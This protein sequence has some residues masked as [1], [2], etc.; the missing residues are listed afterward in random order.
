MWFG[1]LVTMRWWNG[2]W[3]N[4]A[5]ATFMSYLARRRDATGVAGLRLLHAHPCERLRGRRAG[6]DATDRVPGALAGR[7]ERH[8]RHPHV[9]EGRRRT[10][11]ARAV[12]R[13]RAVPRRDPPVP[14]GSTRTATPRRTT[15]GTPS[16]EETGEPVRRVMDAWI[17]QP[18]YPAITVRARRRVA[19]SRPAPLHPIASRRCH[20]VAGAADR[21][22]GGCGRASRST[23]CWSRRD[24]LELPLVVARGCSWSSNAGWR[25]LRS[26]LLRRRPPGAGS[27]ARAFARSHARS[28]GN[29]WSTTPGRPWSPGDAPA[30][31]FV[32][33]VAG[34]A[35]ET[36]LSVWQAIV[37]GLTWCDR[38]VEGA[39]RPVPRLRPRPR[40]SRAR[41]ARLGAIGGETRARPGA[42]RRP[43][44]R[45]R[46]PRATTQRPRRRLAR[47]SRI[48]AGAMSRGRRPRRST[49]WRS[50]VDRTTTSGSARRRGR[51]D[52]AGAGAL[53]VR[54]R[55]VPRPGAVRS[56]VLAATLGR[57]SVRK[58]PR[59]CWCGRVMNRDLG[60]TAWALR[61]DELGRVSA[62]RIAASNVIALAGRRPDAHRARQVR[63]R[64]GVLRRPRHPAEP[65]DAGARTSSASACSPRSA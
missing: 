25:Q 16:E 29:A 56:D 18:G 23:A 59:S 55:A 28:N 61:R 12:A 3:L 52:A 54:A 7:R 62:E 48:R 51:P 19:P 50:P 2:I 32:D 45:A 17:F 49:W 36:D 22:A 33:L 5:F 8:V 64:P 27:T 44:P 53:P 39:A 37:T 60:G 38:F 43:D 31:S 46:H 40:P 15:C 9:H 24:G 30:S 58:T 26:G 47:R 57:T 41:A 6:D 11:H 20:D 4:E 10:P 65:P 1:D 14:R 42:P 21:A 34:F 63:R 35:D 13:T